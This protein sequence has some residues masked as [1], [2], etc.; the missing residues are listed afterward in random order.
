MPSALPR[1]TAVVE[2]PIYEAVELLAKKDGVSLSQKTRDLL[3][4]ALELIED[5]GL[6]AIAEQRRKNK[7]PSISHDELK[8]RLK[9]KLKIK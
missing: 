7:A 2:R 8:R 5:A 9:I 4:E 6:E 1:I 3:L